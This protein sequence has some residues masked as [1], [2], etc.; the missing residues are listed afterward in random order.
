MVGL[1]SIFL[2]ET[3][4]KYWGSEWLKLHRLNTI[5]RTNYCFFD[6]PYWLYHLVLIKAFE[7]TYKLLVNGLNLVKYP[8]SRKQGGYHDSECS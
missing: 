7:C 8:C 3:V 5:M 6:Q 4:E 2:Y 1:Y